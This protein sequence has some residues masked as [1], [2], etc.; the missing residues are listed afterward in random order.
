MQLLNWPGINTHKQSPL[1]NQQGPS[2][3]TGPMLPATLCTLK[4]QWPTTTYLSW[5]VVKTGHHLLELVRQA[6]QTKQLDVPHGGF[7]VA[8]EGCQGCV[9]DVVVAG[10]A[11]QVRHLEVT[12]ASVV[13]GITSIMLGWIIINHAGMNNRAAE[14]MDG[15]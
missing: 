1:T 15:Q 3:A 4:A 14:G 5:T 13:P 9:G 6:E 7:E 11:A 2:W 10:N 8:V 12:G